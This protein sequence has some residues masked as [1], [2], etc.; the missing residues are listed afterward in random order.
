MPRLNGIDAC[1]MWRQI[2]GGRQHLPIVGV[3]AD[4]TAE[5]E[6]RC[7]K[8]GMDVRITKPVDAKLLLAT[9]ENLC[10]PSPQGLAAIENSGPDPMNVV[11]P[12]ST[13]ISRDYQAIDPSQIEYLRSIGDEVFVSGMIEGFF[14]DT[15]QTLE[16]LRLSVH[17]AKVHD[18]RFCAHAIKSSS[19]NMGA[20][21]LAEL[22]SKLERITEAEFDENRFQY[23][24]K[25]ERELDHV[26]DALKAISGDQFYDKM[27]GSIR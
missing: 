3:T 1:M 19:N 7:K 11:V 26:L 14:E 20:K 25:I 5:T 17:D 2:E 23:L 9:I 18:F 12:L 6:I 24:E 27:S 15:E 4:A 13:G 16:P 10:A 22:C 8:A 21:K